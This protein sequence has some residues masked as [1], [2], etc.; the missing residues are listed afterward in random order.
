MPRRGKLGAYGNSIF[1][2]LRKLHTIVAE[3]IYIP[4]NSVYRFLF[5]AF[6]PAFVACVI[7]E[8]ILTG[9]KGVLHTEKEER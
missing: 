8:D 6:S 7:D 4:V 9:M 1:I 5:P 2:F 3:L